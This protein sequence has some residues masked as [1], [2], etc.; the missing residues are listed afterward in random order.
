MTDKCTLIG[1]LK[2]S[3][4]ISLKLFKLWNLH[5]NFGAEL[6]ESDYVP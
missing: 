4:R 5:V 2:R 1:H 6:T 3:L